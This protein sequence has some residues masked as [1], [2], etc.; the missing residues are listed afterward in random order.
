MGNGPDTAWPR[1]D[2]TGAPRGCRVSVWAPLLRPSTWSTPQTASP[3][4]SYAEVAATA[5]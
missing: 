1:V 4:T 2:A 3:L 5:V